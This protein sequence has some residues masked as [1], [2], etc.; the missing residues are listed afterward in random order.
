MCLNFKNVD[1]QLQAKQN[2]LKKL[3]SINLY[4][5]LPVTAYT[6]ERTCKYEVKCLNKKMQYAEI[7]VITFL[8]AGRP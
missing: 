3:L 6:L 5:D 7:R 8:E 1:S 2:I 4:L